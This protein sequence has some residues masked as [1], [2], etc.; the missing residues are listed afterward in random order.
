[1]PLPAFGPRP[2]AH[3]QSQIC[4]NCNCRK[5]I[6]SEKA[7]GIQTQDTQIRS[8][9]LYHESYIYCTCKLLNK[10]CFKLIEEKVNTRKLLKMMSQL[11]YNFGSGSLG[12]QFQKSFFSDPIIQLGLLQSQI[13]NSVPLLPASMSYLLKSF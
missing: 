5:W 12:R 3:E 9:W 4:I 11:Y 6:E 2:Y 8:P 7:G 1:M 10:F 13:S